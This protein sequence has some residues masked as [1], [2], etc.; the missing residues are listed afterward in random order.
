M[1]RNPQFLGFYL[2]L[3]GIS[4]LGRSGYALLL[5]ALAVVYC[6]YYIVNV[7]EPYLARVFGE[8]YVLYRLRTPRYHG[9]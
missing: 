1:S 2:A 8:E 3:F 5:T 4:L 7:E 6:H 9:R